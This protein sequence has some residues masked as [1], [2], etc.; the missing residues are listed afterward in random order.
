MCV[1]VRVCMCVSCACVCLPEGN[2]LETS[3]CGAGNEIP[4]DESTL[5]VGQMALEVVGGMG[6]ALPIS[7]GGGRLCPGLTPCCVAH[8]LPLDKPW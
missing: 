6:L 2:S 8:L 7:W 4:K 1:W 3:G 5:S